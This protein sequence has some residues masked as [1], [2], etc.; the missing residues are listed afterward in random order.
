MKHT[1]GIQVCQVWSEADHGLECSRMTINGV[2]YCKNVFDIFFRKNEPVAHDKVVDRVYLPMETATHTLE[3]K[4]FV[5]DGSPK[6][7]T[8][9]C[10]EAVLTPLSPTQKKKKKKKKK[11]TLLADPRRTAVFGLHPNFVSPRIM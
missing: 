4:I 1:I 7:T 5:S 2:T 8:Q 6:F 11:K 10:T 9:G 3:F